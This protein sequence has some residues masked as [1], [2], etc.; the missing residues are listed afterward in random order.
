MHSGKDVIQA[1]WGLGQS[2]DKSPVTKYWLKNL[3]EWICSLKISL[4]MQ[5][6]FPPFLDSADREQTTG[7]LGF[8]ASSQTDMGLAGKLVVAAGI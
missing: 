6:F 2:R 4:Q 5:I 7:S 3:Y 1:E 8:A